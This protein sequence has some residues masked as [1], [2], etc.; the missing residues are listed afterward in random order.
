MPLK[1]LAQ[2][3]LLRHKEE[4]GEIP[5]GTADKW[6]AHT[7]NPSKLPEHVKKASDLLEFVHADQPGRIMKVA[8]H[9][10]NADATIDMMLDP[11]WNQRDNPYMDQPGGYAKMTLNRTPHTTFAEKLKK[12]IAGGA[13]GGLGSAIA[14]VPVRMIHNPSVFSGGRSAIIKHLALGTAIGASAGTLFAAADEARS[15]MHKKASDKEDSMPKRMGKGALWE[16]IVGA[17]GAAIEAPISKYVFKEHTNLGGGNFWKRIGAG[18]AI[19]GLMGVGGGALGIYGKNKDSSKDETARLSKLL[20]KTANDVH[21]T[22]DGMDFLGSDK[23]PAEAMSEMKTLP[24][25]KPTYPI[26]TD[27]EGLSDRINRNYTQ[28]SQTSV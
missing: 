14:G 5:K 12:D 17:G 16:G 19:G 1:S 22:S 20:G 27:G 15:H 13:V 7:K 3:R 9:M 18:A 11:S 2:E 10:E 28:E 26:I 21:N 4:T 24:S 8:T 6:R 23:D 25:R